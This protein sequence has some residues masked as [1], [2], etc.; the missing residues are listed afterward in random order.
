MTTTE[1]DGLQLSDVLSLNIPL[2]STKSEATSNNL[3]QIPG[4]KPRLEI[5]LG[6]RPSKMMRSADSIEPSIETSGGASTVVAR[7]ET[8][9]LR[10][11]TRWRYGGLANGI[12]LG[13]ALTAV[14]VASAGYA[15][16]PFEFVWNLIWAPFL[17]VVI[18][19]ALSRTQPIEPSVETSGGASAVVARDE[20]ERLRTRTRWGYG[21]LA[22]GIGLGFAL[23]AV[24]VARAGYAILLFHFARN[25]TWAPF[26]GLVIGRALSPTQPKQLRIHTLMVIV[27]YVAL[28]LGV[29]VSTARIGFAAQRYLQETINCA[30]RVK[31]YREEA[32]KCDAEAK[33]KRKNVTELQA[34]RIPEGLHQIQR[35]FLQSLEDNAKA[36]PDYRTYRRGIITEGEEQNRIRMENNVVVLRRIAEHF[37]RLAAKYEWFQWHPWLPIEPDPPVPN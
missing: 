19:R 15:I 6:R 34:G 13:F 37:E 5:K 17:G 9:R 4:V 16:L 35:A 33:L 10:T 25:M 24:Q 20:A 11:C 26:L 8:E 28:L 7:D 18:G 14:Q 12:G 36:T 30:E 3:R 27:A 29:S 2:A 1:E 22:I 23:T 32:R 21:G 31:I